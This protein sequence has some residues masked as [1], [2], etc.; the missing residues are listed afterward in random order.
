MVDMGFYT[1]LFSYLCFIQQN[2][3]E[4]V[5][6]KAFPGVPWLIL[7]VCIHHNCAQAG[8]NLLNKLYFCNPISHSLMVLN[9]AFAL[10]LNGK[11]SNTPNLGALL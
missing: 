7:S 8:G 9:C 1:M 10:A 3:H 2:Y 11:G 5:G 4:N 6:S